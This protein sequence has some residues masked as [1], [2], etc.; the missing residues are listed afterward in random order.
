MRKII[1]SF[2]SCELESE[3]EQMGDN[4][5][6]LITTWSIVAQHYNIGFQISFHVS[7]T[8]N[9]TSLFW[10]SHKKISR[11]A[12]TARH[13]LGHKKIFMPWWIISI[14]FFHFQVFVSLTKPEK[15]RLCILPTWKI[16]WQLSEKLVQLV[17]MEALTHQPSAVLS[18]DL[19]LTEFI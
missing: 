11:H 3:P 16:F 7:G 10:K 2:K 17:G 14:F 5:I 13:M 12:G 15:K 18:G 1:D 4:P 8:W 6:S 9:C 19:N